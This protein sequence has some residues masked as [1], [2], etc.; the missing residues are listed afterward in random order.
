MKKKRNT[1]LDVS[2]GRGRKLRRDEHVG[3]MSGRIRRTR[4]IKLGF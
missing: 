3:I 4:K 1:I 2:E